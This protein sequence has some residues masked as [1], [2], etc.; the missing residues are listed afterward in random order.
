MEAFQVFADGVGHGYFD[1]V[2]RLFP[3]DGNS[4]VL[5]ARWVN[6]DVVILLECIEEV[7]GVIGGEEFDS[8]VIYS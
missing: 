3:I 6:G 7:G 5:A 8:K 4:V 1:I 2:F